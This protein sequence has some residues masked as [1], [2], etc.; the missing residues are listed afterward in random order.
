[1]LV[2]LYHRFASPSKGVLLY[3]KVIALMTLSINPT[4]AQSPILH[5][6]D[7]SDGLPHS[8]I[9]DIHQDSLGFLWFGTDGGGLAKYD[10][11]QF[12]SFTHFDGLTDQA[13]YKIVEDRQNNLWI[14]T[15]SGLFRFNGEDFTT[16]TTDDGLLDNRVLSLLTTQTGVIA[17]TARG[18]S[19]LADHSSE[20]WRKAEI[21]SQIPTSGEVRALA[22]YA[23]TLWIGTSEGLYMVENPTGHSQPM[24]QTID[25]NVD[26]K[27][28]HLDSDRQIVVGTTR[29]ML[30]VKNEGVS[31]VFDSVLAHSQIN[32]IITDEA[33]MMWIGTNDGVFVSDGNSIQRFG[34]ALLEDIWSI[35]QDRDLNIWFGTNGSGLY[36]YSQTPF[37]QIS[38]IDGLPGNIVM[39]I[40]QDEREH[41]WIG[42]DNGAVRFSE[43]LRNR[44][45]ISDEL[46]DNR[47]RDILTK[48]DSI[49]FATDGG[50]ALL[51]EAGFS[52][53]L[54]ID[55]S[56]LGEIRKVF[57]ASNGDIWF[58]TRNRGAIRFR[59]GE[60]TIITTQD[61]LPNNTVWDFAES[62]T[63]AIWIGTFGGICR[64]RGDTIE[65]FPTEPALSHSSVTTLY[66][67]SSGKLW[68]GTHSGINIIDLEELGKVP[69]VI[70]TSHGLSD[71]SILAIVQD[72]FGDMWI[73]TNDGLNRLDMRAYRANGDKIIHRYSVSEGF[74]GTEVNLHAG[75]ADTGGRLWFGTVNG[76]L[77]FSNSKFHD[78]SPEIPV[79]ITDIKLFH[80]P[81]DFEQYSAGQSQKQVPTSFQFPH[82][83]NHL[84]F[85]YVG[86]DFN[87]NDLEYR[88]RLDGFDTVW[89]PSS[90]SRSVTYS[91]LKPGSFKFQ[92][93]ARAGDS[94][95][96]TNSDQ[97]IIIEIQKPFWKKWWFRVLMFC[98]FASLL[99]VVHRA[100]SRLL[101]KR[102]VELEHIKASER[103]RVQS[104]AT[105]D[106]HD[107]LGHLVTRISLF[108]ELLRQKKLPRDAQG[109][110]NQIVG[111]ASTLSSGMGD[112]LWTL[113]PTRKTLF[114]VAIRL[115][116]FCDSLF[117]GTSVSFR[118]TGLT[119]S[120]RSIQLTAE[121]QRHLTLFVKEAM[122][123]LLR[124]SASN[125]ADLNFS[126]VGKGVTVSIVDQGVGLDTRENI[127]YGYGF[128][129]LNARAKALGGEVVVDSRLGIGTTLHLI[130]EVPNQSN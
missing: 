86:L 91:N 63:G 97:S 61:G 64:V 102:A 73:G 62:P 88:F 130:F 77:I 12:E 14:A 70:N 111:T 123:N 23:D 122:T 3:F 85:E 116:D 108:G 56:D 125:S 78:R 115:K 4:Q 124:H 29:G 52:N 37:E 113:D 83:L 43:S 79:Y 128:R 74:V 95:W 48:A 103:Y 71:N 34:A 80:E 6:Y 58:G 81:F 31:G 82:H 105:T 42:T 94:E 17:G 119:E 117:E 2:S 33:G 36:R 89:S 19:I 51:T 5:H 26:V 121:A 24:L 110:V 69:D 44:H 16:Y 45:V 120:L 93:Q 9:S 20:K 75:Y 114:D 49:W 127:K 60:F 22:L 35:A 96:T 53:Y 104:K 38:T 101:T 106:F 40:T 67:E 54:S 126:V 32:E 1:M 65:D 98:M 66:M 10:G 76:A 39:T 90:R 11:Y 112:F 7:R 129:N 57:A 47:V 28:I 50:I 15:V 118:V 27:V 59:S 84:T 100:R 13:L 72:A 107:E 8:Q 99:F 21:V 109:I 41:Y 46:P 68:L 87:R 92:V 55:G 18:V 25:Q 30:R